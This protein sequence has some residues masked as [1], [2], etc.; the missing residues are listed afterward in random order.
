MDVI[1]ADH[2]R[3]LALQGACFLHR[4]PKLLEASERGFARGA[5]AVAPHHNDA[6]TSAGCARVIHASVK[7]NQVAALQQHVMI[8]ISHAEMHSGGG[9]RDDF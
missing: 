1:L 7:V 4:V 6:E 2:T 8:A 9:Q 5:S 3:H